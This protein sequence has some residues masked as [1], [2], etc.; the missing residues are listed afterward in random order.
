M[1]QAA[2]AVAR[3]HSFQRLHDQLIVIH[4]H[5]DLLVNRRQLVLSR[6]HLIVLC[7]R[8]YAQLPQLH[9]H[10]MHEGGDPRP[11]RPEIMIVQLLALRRH[12]AEQRPSR[13]DQIHPFQV[14]GA[15]DDEILLLRAHIRC[16]PF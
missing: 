5:V 1:K 14:V 6:S 16:H 13:E 2:E 7:L 8:G 12:R 9:V 11:E 10:V 4:R 3:R 15:V